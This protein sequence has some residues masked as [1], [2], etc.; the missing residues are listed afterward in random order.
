M[1]EAKVRA[2]L[3]KRYLGKGWKENPQPN[4][5]NWI[6]KSLPDNHDLSVRY[7]VKDSKPHYVV[8]LFNC[9]IEQS[10]VECSELNQVKAEV[11]RLEMFV[12]KKLATEDTECFTDSD[13]TELVADLYRRLHDVDAL[14]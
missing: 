7:N 14:I 10:E 9:G 8:C 1:D 2:Y 13:V 6:T 5:P 11:R 4:D 12:Y 3:L